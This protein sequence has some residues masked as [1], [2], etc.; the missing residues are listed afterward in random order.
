MDFDFCFVD[1]GQDWTIHE[2]TIIKEIF[3]ENNIVVAHG[4]AQNIRSSELHWNR[5][6]KDDEYRIVHTRKAL[7]MKSIYQILLKNLLTSLLRI[8]NLLLSL[9]MMNQLVVK[10]IWSSET[11]SKIPQY[12]KVLSITS[13]MTLKQLITYFVSMKKELRKNIRSILGICGL[14]MT[15]IL[16]EFNRASLIMQ[17]LFSTTH[18]EAWRVDYI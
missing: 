18:A 2:Q 9:R 4:K 3:G 15:S 8:T 10:Y 12:T 1:E 17:G 6:H 13:Q 16:E 14:A 7:R 5:G 11:T